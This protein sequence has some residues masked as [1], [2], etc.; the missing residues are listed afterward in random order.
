MSSMQPF[1]G[2]GEEPK[3]S[4][5]LLVA[6]ATGYAGGYTAALGVTGSSIDSVTSAAVASVQGVIAAACWVF[7]QRR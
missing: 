1:P 2:R 3:R 5:G 6:L 7:W 4:N